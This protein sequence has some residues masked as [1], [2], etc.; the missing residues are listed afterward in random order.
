G[1]RLPATILNRFG[2]PTPAQLV[3]EPQPG[4]GGRPLRIVLIDTISPECAR[5]GNLAAGSEE[6]RREQMAR[7]LE[8]E[9]TARE[10]QSFSHTVAHDLRGPLRVVDGFARIL[11]GDFAPAMPAD[12]RGHLDRILAAAQRMNEMIDALLAMARISTQRV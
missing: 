6:A 4:P 8:L 1:Y 9:V 7:S 3:V 12:A 10:L 2:E 5:L 11:L